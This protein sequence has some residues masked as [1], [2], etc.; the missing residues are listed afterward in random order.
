MNR[1]L[2]LALT[3]VLFARPSSSQSNSPVVGTSLDGAGNLTVTLRNNASSS[4]LTAYAWTSTYHGLTTDGKFAPDFITQHEIT[5]AAFK[6]T[7][8]PIVPGQELT[9]QPSG[10]SPEFVFRAAVWADGTTYGDPVWIR[11]ILHIREVAA[12]NLD[13][14]I[15]M[16]RNAIQR[17][18]SASDVIGQGQAGNTR[19]TAERESVEES[20]VVGRYYSTLNQAMTNPPTHKDGATYTLKENLAGLLEHFEEVRDHLRPYE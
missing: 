13:S 8:K 2:G 19:L 12:K 18:T 7:V 20:V 10:L 5:D 3:I 16:L 4:A 1:L 17:N 15:L 9:F 6:P 11:R 14:I